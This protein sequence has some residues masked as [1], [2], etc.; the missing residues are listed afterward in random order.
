MKKAKRHQSLNENSNL[1]KEFIIIYLQIEKKN[2]F[3]FVTQL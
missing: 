2:S 1:K 3:S